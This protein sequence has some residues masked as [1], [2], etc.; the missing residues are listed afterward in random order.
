MEKEDLVCIDHGKPCQ[1]YCENDMCMYPL[2]CEEC[3]KM[4]K[5]EYDAKN[6]KIV[7][8]A[9]LFSDKTVKSEFIKEYN[10][11]MKTID[12]ETQEKKEILKGAYNEFTHEVLQAC[13]KYYINNNVDNVLEEL[14][15]E[16]EMSKVEYQNHMT[17]ETL[18]K[19]AEDYLRLRKVDEAIQNNNRFIMSREQIFQNI[20]NELENLNGM[21]QEQLTK[22]ESGYKQQLQNVVDYDIESHL[23]RLMEKQEEQDEREEEN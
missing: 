21:V 19:M 6:H 9:S 20:E 11:E 8:V 4:H 5:I 12:K 10:T 2:L 3:L 22:L 1:F 7:P 14:R 18:R 13:H 17:Q 15:N 16:F 23:E